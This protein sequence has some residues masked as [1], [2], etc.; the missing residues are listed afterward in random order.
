MADQVV[1]D[2]G[3]WDVYK[4]PDIKVQIFEGLPCG[5]VRETSYGVDPPVAH[6]I[7]WAYESLLKS[8]QHP[9]VAPVQNPQA[10]YN[11]KLRSAS[12]PMQT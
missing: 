6:G 9:P 7:C 1:F 3:G 2:D 5:T 10:G 11:K 8:R 12:K 4:L